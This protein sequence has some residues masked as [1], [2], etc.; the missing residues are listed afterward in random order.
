MVT[1]ERIYR[2]MFYWIA[3]AVL[4]GFIVGHKIGFE[5]CRNMIIDIMLKEIK[6]LEEK[7][8]L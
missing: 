8:K 5:N 4:V 6:D 2:L 1:T 7:D 3:M